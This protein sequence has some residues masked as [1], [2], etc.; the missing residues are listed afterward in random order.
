MVDCNPV[1]VIFLDRDGTINEEVEYLHNKQE[2]SLL[3]TVTEALRLFR[4]RGYTIVVI[5]NQAGVAR[6]YYTETDV[7]NLHQ[8]LNEVLAEEQTHIDSFYYCPHHPEYGI[9]DY[10]V[11]CECRKP[12][13]GMFEMAAKEYNI[14]KA[15]SWMIG[16]K[17]LDIEAG[18]AFGVQTVLVATGYGSKEKELADAG[19]G[20]VT[21]DLF[22]KTLMD[23]ATMIVGRDEVKNGQ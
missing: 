8:Y 13:I 2:L 4:E 23:A 18:K 22:A 16:D 5:T 3:P 7:I 9:G 10:K 11:A 15:R 6:G 14:D 1:P 20:D 21:Y 12:G 17:L 19:D